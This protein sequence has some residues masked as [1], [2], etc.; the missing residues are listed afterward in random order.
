MNRPV[1]PFWASFIVAF[2]LIFW[3]AA[4]YAAAKAFGVI[5]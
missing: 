2:W 5:Q 4:G 3:I 1:P